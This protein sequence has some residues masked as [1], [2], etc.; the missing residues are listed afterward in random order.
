MICQYLAWAFVRVMQIKVLRYV[1]QLILHH[2]Y[3]PPFNWY[4]IFAP[5]R[6]FFSLLC[7]W[8]W[9]VVLAPKV[10]IAKHPLKQN[11]R[12]KLS[13]LSLIFWASLSSRIRRGL[14]K[15]E[16]GKCVAWRRRRFLG[17]RKKVCQRIGKK[18]FSCFS[19]YINVWGSMEITFFEMMKIFLLLPTFNSSIRGDTFSQILKIAFET[20][21]S[22]LIFL[23]QPLFHAPAFF[24]SFR[25]F[26]Q[27]R[28]RRRRFVFPRQ[29]SLVSSADE[30]WRFEGEKGNICASIMSCFT[31]NKFM[32]VVSG[33]VKPS[34]SPKRKQQNLR[35]EIVQEPPRDEDRIGSP[36]IGQMRN[37]AASFSSV[38]SSGLEVSKNFNK[39]FSSF[40]IFPSKW[41]LLGSKIPL[42][43]FKKF[44]LHLEFLTRSRLRSFFP[45]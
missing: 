29:F 10:R 31:V 35:I 37:K 8:V 6:L 40:A 12:C 9:Q 22:N 26:S 7:H 38:A 13:S 18:V 42:W 24:S 4:F 43:G 11:Y 14:E 23:C 5:K 32:D 39:L 19:H 41:P 45:D 33:H 3:F 36:L 44:F 1:G 16:W 21:L 27:E 20:W 15:S 30:K 2:M 34:P 25:C 28:A 17:L